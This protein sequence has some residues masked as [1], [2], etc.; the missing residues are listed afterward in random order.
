LLRTANFPPSPNPE[1]ELNKKHPD[2]SNYFSFLIDSQD[3]WINHHQLGVDGS[4]MHL[5]KDNP[6]LLHLY[7]LSYE[8]NTLI[9]HFLVNRE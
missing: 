3:R 5:D 9:A 2:E 6:N 8:R 7:L 4:I 1:A